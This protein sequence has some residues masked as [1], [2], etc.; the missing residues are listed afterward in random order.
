MLYDTEDMITDLRKP[1]AEPGS[2]V[3][4]SLNILIL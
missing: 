1:L 2:G 4:V 3:T